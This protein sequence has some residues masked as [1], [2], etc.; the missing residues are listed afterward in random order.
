MQVQRAALEITLLVASSLRICWAL[1]A[2][3]SLGE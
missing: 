3:P 1:L 2:G